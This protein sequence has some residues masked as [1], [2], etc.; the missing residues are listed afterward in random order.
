MSDEINLPEDW[1][2]WEL[3]QLNKKFFWEIRRKK[4][5][6]SNQQVIFRNTKPMNEP[7]INK[8]AAQLSEPLG[9]SLEIICLR[10]AD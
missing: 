8:E 5:A 3:E 9:C 6:G 2:P 4:E 1:E 10:T 7:E